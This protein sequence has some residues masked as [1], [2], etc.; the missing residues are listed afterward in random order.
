[1]SVLATLFEHNRWANLRLIEAC[2]RVPDEVLD[3]EVPGAYGPIR[4]TV[5]HLASAEQRYVG[6]LKGRPVEPRVHET[7]GFPGWDG[8]AASLGETGS[9]ALEYAKTVKPD[10]VIRG[11]RQ[12]GEAYEVPAQTLLLQVINHATEHRVNVTTA[13]TA[14]GVEAPV[15]DGWA[16][17]EAA[18]RGG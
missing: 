14:R 10:E 8:L 1:M 18:D 3:A 9:A 17:G 4:S 7:L 6:A 5:L 15:L 12:N 16:F 13:L 2:R 11:R